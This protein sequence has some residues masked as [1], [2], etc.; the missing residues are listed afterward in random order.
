MKGQDTKDLYSKYSKIVSGELQ[1]SPLLVSR[2]K[3]GQNKRGEGNKSEQKWGRFAALV[4][5][6]GRPRRQSSQIGRPPLYLD[7][8]SA[9]FSAFVNDKFQPRHKARYITH[10]ECLSCFCSAFLPDWS[11]LLLLRVHCRQLPVKC[12]RHCRLTIPPSLTKN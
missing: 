9:L 2:E 1:C 12:D 10:R 5:G 4:S 7:R 3:E 8:S 6:A 11:A